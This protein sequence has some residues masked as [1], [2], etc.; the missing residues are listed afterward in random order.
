MSQIYDTGDTLLTTT[1]GAPASAIPENEMSSLT[2]V[3]LNNYAAKIVKIVIELTDCAAVTGSLYIFSETNAGWVVA[4]DDATGQAPMATT[5][6]MATIS[7]DELGEI[8]DT[9]RYFANN[10]TTDR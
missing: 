7:C 4:T 5:G 9:V 1:T 2:S 8:S 3:T 6:H 10:D